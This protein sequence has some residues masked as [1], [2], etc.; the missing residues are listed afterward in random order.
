M[1]DQRADR[2]IQQGLTSWME[3]A[4]PTQAPTRLLEG[5]FAQ[6]MKTAQARVYPWNRLGGGSQARVAL[7]L[8]GALL[9]VAMAALLSSGSRQ[10]P[11]PTPGSSP[12]P[13]PTP[14]L[15]PT[16][17]PRPTGQP[18]Q[19]TAPLPPST[20]ITAEATI[21]EPDLL[22]FQ[23]DGT[24]LW[25][26]APGRIDR[27]DPSTNKVTGSVPVGKTTDLFNGLAV[28]EDGLWATEWYSATIYRVDPATLTVVA[29]IPVGLAPKGILAN[30]EGVWVAD[31]HGGAVLRIDPATNTV[32]ATIEVGPL[33]NS[34][35][36]WLASGLGSIWVD[37]PNDFS[38]VRIDPITNAIQATIDVP[39]GFTACGGFAIGT[40][41]AWV[42]G[43]DASAA[44]GRIDPGTN[45]PVTVVP[46]P[47]TGGPTYIGG[48]L[49][50]SVDTGDAS[51]GMLVRIDPATNTIDRLV[52]PDQPFGGGGGMVV[53]GESVWVTDGYNGV[54]LRFPLA[55]F[56]G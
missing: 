16:Q 22:G 53:L 30:A 27:I 33:G 35:P 54:V 7:I 55:A 14:T 21:P 47:G 3:S 1:T 42:S 2:H 10:T 39:D 28:N 15:I 25:A 34:G 19:T 52:A 4:A 6:T 48:A 40:D 23:T 44:L 43:C 13:S 5:T 56:S 46:M 17:R 8:I 51:T 36:N 50:V 29:S 41:V 12:I 45:A 26:L 31:T 9:V 49:W 24:L 37:I 32:I 20:S 38:I 11:G 18:V